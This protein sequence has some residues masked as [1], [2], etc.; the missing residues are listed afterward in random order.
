[1]RRGQVTIFVIVGIALLLLVLLYLFR[2]TQFEPDVAGGEG[3]AVIE[4]MVSSCTEESLE[5]LLRTAGANGGHLDISHLRRSANAWEADLVEFPP[6][7]VPYW[8]HLRPCPNSELGCEASAQPPLCKMGSSCPLASYG[9]KSLQEQLELALPGELLDCL[10][11][12]NR[13]AEY[14]IEARGAPEAEILFTAEGVVATIDFPLS[15]LEIASGETYRLNDF[16]GRADVNIAKVYTFAHEI[17]TAQRNSSF[18]EALTLHL[19]SIYS[20]VEAPLP[21]MR[22]VSVL[23]QKRYWSRTQVER[24]L[25][26][27]LLPWVNFIQVPNAPASF[28]PI[29]P[30]ADSELTAEEQQLYAGIFFFLNQRVSETFYEGMGVRFFYPGTRPLLSINGGAEVLQPRSA[31]VGGFLQKIVGMFLND[32]RFRYT[33]SYPVIVTIRDE[34]AFG[35]EGYDWSFAMEANIFRNQ[36]VDRSETVD[37]FLLVDERV[38]FSSP[39]QRVKKRITLTV[40]D[41]EQEQRAILA[42]LSGVQVNYECGNSFYIGTTDHNGQLETRFPYCR[43]GGVIRLS[44][45]GY[46]GSGLPFDNYV[47]G[48]EEALQFSLWPLKNVTLSMRKRTDT[49][50]EELRSSVPN[51]FTILN[52][53]SALNKSDMAIFSIERVKETPYDEELPMVGFYTF[54]VVE[55]NFSSEIAAQE[56]HLEQLRQQGI[57]TD[58]DVAEWLL[59]LEEQEAI[60]TPAQPAVSVLIAPGRYV[61]D[62][63]I[64]HNEQISIPE[65][66]REFCEM[67]I[68]IGGVCLSSKEYT[69]NETNF[70]AWMK[71]GIRYDDDAPYEI[72]WN[73][74]YNTEELTFYMLEQKIPSEW[75]DLEEY[76]S[77][78]DFLDQQGLRLLQGPTYGTDS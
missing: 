72:T 74:L 53:S 68:P 8:T 25:Q 37:S 36:P 13:L 1:M 6:Q 44:K 17:A 38:D 29:L 19:L 76:Q 41:R 45:Q 47:E 33:L 15:I 52:K 71:G 73:Q 65:E 18:L 21:P 22:A 46:L 40:L 48:G 14:E 2:T 59:A 10:D 11:N 66:T 23:G 57:L 31:D 9:E 55:Q 51:L 12:F 27:E 70:T 35:G 28:R 63:F 32:Y 20:G 56:R 69:L 5:R 50:V 61:I 39:I 26:D 54:S 24:I 43:Y 4:G 34:N 30:P 58:A 77:I 16:S 60:V 62:G 64:L 49:Q 75:K 7:T 42:P 67:P 3:A 78:D